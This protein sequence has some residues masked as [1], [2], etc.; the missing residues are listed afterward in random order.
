MTV[1]DIVI[2][3]YAFSGEK[4]KEEDNYIKEMGIKLC[5]TV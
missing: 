5:P 4:K 1:V 3:I 2:Y